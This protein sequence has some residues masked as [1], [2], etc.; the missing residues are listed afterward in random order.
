MFYIRYIRYIRLFSTPEHIFHAI[1][2][3]LSVGNS[4]VRKKRTDQLSS[5]FQ[6]VLN[7]AREDLGKRA[8]RRSCGLVDVLGAP[9]TAES[10]EDLPRPAHSTSIASACCS[11]FEPADGTAA[12]FE[13]KRKKSKKSLCP[14]TTQNAQIDATCSHKMKQDATY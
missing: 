8:K 14:I 10:C 9:R 7:P 6:V 1:T 2:S 12:F 11:F 5:I 4:A 13:E 3:F